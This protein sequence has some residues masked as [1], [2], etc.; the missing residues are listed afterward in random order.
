MRARMLASVH[1]KNYRAFEDTGEVNLSRLNVFIGANNAGKTSFVSTIELLLRSMRGGGSR[2]PLLFQEM[3]SFSSFN[4]VLRRH[5][6]PQESRPK[7]FKL[8]FTLQ[9]ARKQGV[10]V[11]FECSGD[12]KDDTPV[13]DAINYKIGTFDTSIKITRPSATPTELRITSSKSKDEKSSPAFFHGF[14]PLPTE[15]PNKKL[16]ALFRL[17]VSND[18][19]REPQRLEVIH[20]SRPVPRS[21]YVIDDPGLT[22]EN[23]ELITFLLRTWDASSDVQVKNRIVESLTTLGLTRA[24]E[25]IADSRRSGPKVV[26]IRVAPSLKRQK[27]TIADAGFGLSQVLPLVAYEA[28]LNNGCLIAYQPEL[29]L[30]PWAQSRLA[31][32]FASSI[33]RGNQLFVETHSPDFILRLQLL[34]AQRKL[35]PS[36]VTVFCFEQDKG[37]ARIRPIVF[38]KDGVPAESWPKGFLDTSLG[39]A[40]ELSSARL[41]NSD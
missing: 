39:I 4:S 26:E 19:M 5:W 9:G 1:L 11:E 28:R 38:S 16:Q 36:D 20:P 32:I 17:L 41:A 8:G 10:N 37:R 29:H 6:S 27:V 12:A 2:G 18:V 33:S 23:R 22:A 35:A 14:V 15:R 13:V 34:M 31:D 21:Y 40:R 25:V 30:H 3:A 24:F 7:H